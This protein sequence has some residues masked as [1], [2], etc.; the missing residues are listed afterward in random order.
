M[1]ENLNLKNGLNPLRTSLPKG[2]YI[3]QTQTESVR[4]LVK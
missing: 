2:N 1:I 3:L 4:F